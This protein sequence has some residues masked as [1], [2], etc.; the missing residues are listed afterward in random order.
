VAMRNVGLASDRKSSFQSRNLSKKKKSNDGWELIVGATV[1]GLVQTSQIASTIHKKEPKSRQE[2]FKLIHRVKLSLA[3][4]LSCNPRRLQVVP[5]SSFLSRNQI[6]LPKN[7][8]R[9]LVVI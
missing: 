2:A 8:N 4:L 6:V 1:Y 9:N 5:G 7:S 3:G